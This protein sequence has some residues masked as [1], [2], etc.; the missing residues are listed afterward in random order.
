MYFLKMASSK[1]NQRGDAHP[2]DN[3]GEE[4]VERT[5]LH[6]MDVR[7]GKEILRGNIRKCVLCPG[8]N[9]GSYCATV[10]R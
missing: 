3:K 1:A 9:G 7:V 5:L 8:K 6:L 4:G 2:A 10:C